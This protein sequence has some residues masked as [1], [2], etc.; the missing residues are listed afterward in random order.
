MSDMN[1]HFTICFFFGL[2]IM[3]S[4]T[5]SPEKKAETLIKKAIIDEVSTL[6]SLSYK[7]VETILDSA[8]SPIDN[9]DYINLVIK[10][11]DQYE[12]IDKIKEEIQNAR[13]DEAQLKSYNYIT[14]EY[15]E[16]NRL[17]IAQAKEKREAA[18]RKLEKVKI[19]IQDSYSE[20][21][22]IVN[23]GEFFIGYYVVH[24]YRVGIKSKLMLPET[25]YYLLNKDLSSII[26][27]WTEED[28][29]HYNQCLDELKEMIKNK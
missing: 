24:S 8:F 2:F 13:L 12:E 27:T 20:A 16:Y 23:K 28:I 4:C 18:E 14:T 3:V 5:Q 22:K 26:T 29:E 10:I 15:K 11:H 6:P 1:K 7:P 17:R 9:P 25:S 19:Q 21:Q